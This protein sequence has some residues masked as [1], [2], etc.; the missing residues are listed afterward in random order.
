MKAI[1]LSTAA[2]LASFVAISSA[3]AADLG[4]APVEPVA[5][6]IFTWTG[7]YL[8]AHI[9][10]GWANEHDDQSDHLNGSGTSG[11]VPP[12]C[13]CAPPAKIADSFSMDGVIG[14]VHAGYNWQFEEGTGGGWVVGVEGDLDAADINGS[15]DFNGFLNDGTFVSG[16]LKMK[17]DW[18]GSLRLRGGYGWDRFLLYATGGIAFAEAKLSI[19]SDSSSDISFSGSTSSTLT[20]WLLG[21]GVEYAFTDNWIGRAEVYYADFGKDTFHTDHIGD[22]KA[23]FHETVATVG[24][25]YKF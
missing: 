16:Q 10:W 9:G 11:E 19:D 15:H 17:S 24:I 6:V 7:P 3:S 4:P 1:V 5:P 8:G 2:A 21:G 20:G 13:D 14:G 23:G 12:P 22:V 25:S 18:Q